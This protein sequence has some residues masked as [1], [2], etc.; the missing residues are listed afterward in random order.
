MVS[1]QYGLPTYRCKT[2]NYTG[3]LIVELDD[4]APLPKIRKPPKKHTRQNDP[5]LVME[6][7]RILWVILVILLMILTLLRLAHVSIPL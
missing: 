7:R 6:G 3:Q 1:R 5:V 2:C 4:N